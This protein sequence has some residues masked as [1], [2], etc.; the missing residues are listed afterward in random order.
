MSRL[1][2]YL[3][4]LPVLLRGVKNWPSAL[5]GIAAGKSF[6]LELQDGLRLQVRGLMDVWIVKE[7]CLDRQYERFAVP[8]QDGWSV[9]DIG[10]GLGDFAISVGRAHPHCRVLG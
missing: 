10:A 1:S 5:A 7:T 4:S 6:L 8:I 3:A 2:Y 9:L